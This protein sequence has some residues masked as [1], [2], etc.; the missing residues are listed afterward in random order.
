MKIIVFFLCFVCVNC[1]AQ[2]K[3]DNVG[4]VG[5]GT[6]IPKE[7]F[8][9][10]DRWGFHNGGIKAITFNNYWDDLAGYPKRMVDGYASSLN[11]NVDGSIA[12]SIGDNGLSGSGVQMTPTVLINGS[13]AALQIGNSWNFQDGGNKSINYNV[14]WNQSA[15]SVKR[16]TNGMGSSMSFSGDGSII[17]SV[18][19]YGAA[20]SSATMYQAIKINGYGGAANIAVGNF[21]PT[22]RLD[23]LGY[24]RGNQYLL[25]SDRRFKSKIRQID[26]AMTLVNE[27]Q[28][29]FYSFSD[30]RLSGIDKKEVS[31]YGFIAQD[32]QAILPELVFED[33]EGYLSMNYDGI[34]PVLTEALKEKHL[35]IEALEKRISLLEE[36][37][38]YTTSNN[39][40]SDRNYIKQNRPNPFD[41]E[42]VIQ[43][44]IKS[45]VGKAIVYFFD[46]SGKMIKDID[47]NQRG[48]QDVVISANTLQ[49]GMY[50]YT[51]VCDGQEIDTKKMIVTK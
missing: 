16:M 3:V 47:I 17:F 28:G 13:K 27:L 32:V 46:M 14:Y 1:F 5:V 21:T 34:I 11:F 19:D 40:Q 20:E 15:G 49:A 4:R 30:Q 6:F 38:E 12:F 43:V 22:Y 29:K 36:R 35:E 18:A 44:N 8:Q 24:V 26:N 2:L 25:G 7:H 45:S 23:V 9:I 50:Y 48:T 42:S 31:T 33:K 37:L 51:L 10:G 39:L 41:R